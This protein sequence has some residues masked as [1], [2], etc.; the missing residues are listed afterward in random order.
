MTMKISNVLI[1]FISS[2]LDDT[3]G[4]ENL[5]KTKGMNINTGF[6]NWSYYRPIHLAAERGKKIQL[7]FC[8]R[9]VV[10]I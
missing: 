9:T 6:G 7:N 1:P 5:I 3:S 10:L 2:H 8:G 4:I